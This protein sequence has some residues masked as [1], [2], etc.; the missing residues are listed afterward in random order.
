MTYYGGLRRLKPEVRKRI[1]DRL[2][3]LRDQLETKIPARNMN[4]TLLLA[5]WNIRDFD[6]N[7][8]GH[9]KRLKESFYYMAE[10]ISAFDLVAVQE[11][12]ENM[13]GLKALMK[14]L[15]RSWEFIATD[16]AEGSAGN[17]ERMVFLYDR[18]KVRFRDIAGEIVLPYKP[19]LP[20]KKSVL[21][22]AET[23]K[24]MT[25]GEFTRLMK[26][27]DQKNPNRQF[28]RTPFLVAFQSGWFKFKLCTVHIYFGETSGPKFKRRVKEIRNI[29][30]FLKK[31]ADRDKTDNFILLGDFNI[32]S[33]EHETMEALQANGFTVPEEIQ[34]SNVKETKFYDQIAFCVREEH[35]VPR[36]ADVF[37]F[38]KSVFRDE[39]YETY[40]PLM[41]RL[42]SQID[43]SEPDGEKRAYY[44]NTWRTFQ[45][46]DHMPMWVELKIDFSDQ[47]LKDRRDEN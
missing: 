41:E 14:L 25:A 38:T 19:D 26:A 39:D 1:A 31:R 2:I 7:K 44:Q 37:S 30:R 6:S 32:V 18:D 23:A 10:I 5:S 21:E 17:K 33:P 9:G 20:T 16:V 24:S 47:Y 27:E 43:G 8:F 40:R 12:N 22:L 36:R 11:V 13:S 34:K 4:D 42:S 28:S 3:D 15:G 45:M 35:L 46:S 29:A